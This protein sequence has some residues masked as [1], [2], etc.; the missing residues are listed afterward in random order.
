MKKPLYYFLLL[1]LTACT[2]YGLD[3]AVNINPSTD[4][5]IVPMSD[6]LHIATSFMTENEI[7][8][9]TKADD[10]SVKSFFSLNSKTN[11]PL[12]HVINYE[13][14]GFAIIAADMRL[15]PIQA[16]S[17]SG[18]FEDDV[19]SFP[20]GLTIW[21]N[22]AESSKEG[23]TEPD[24]E[25]L[26]AWKRYKPDAF[27]IEKLKTKSLEP[28]LGLPQEEVDT[29]VGPLIHDSWYQGSPYNDSLIVCPHYSFNQALFPYPHTVKEYAG[30]FKP[31]VGCLPLA[32]ARVL[33][34]NQIP[35][36]YNW[37]NMPNWAPQTPQTKS[38]IRDVHYA[39]KDYAESNNKVFDYIYDQGDLSTG[40]DKS[41]DIGEFLCSQYGFPVAVTRSYSSGVE[42][43]IQREIFDYH[44]PCI[45][46]GS[47]SPSS[48]HVWVCDGYR[49]VFYPD[50]DPDGGFIGG[51]EFKY[52]H[53]RWGMEDRAYDG[54]FQHYNYTLNG[55]SFQYDMKLTHHI[56]I[57]DHWEDEL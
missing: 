35:I 57:V 15:K 24:D 25:T 16:Y 42:E 41:F 14:G 37:L 56:S 22:C 17:P 36:N 27:H 4:S 55:I 49:Y 20:L 39:V 5:F 50:F 48:G 18:H 21:L 43:L 40:V 19:A 28:G 6:A 53:H 32:I 1:G 34:Y 10:L 33:R 47:S 45:L 54:W 31:V 38:F 2:V 29:L 7:I 46:S 11:S 8:P 3:D 13:G 23:I 44:L 9:T 30:Q 26:M 52:L 51:F 12:L